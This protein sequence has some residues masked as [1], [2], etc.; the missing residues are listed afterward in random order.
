MIADE[1]ISYQKDLLISFLLL[2]FSD[3]SCAMNIINISA[4]VSVKIFGLIAASI[5]HALQ[6]MFYRLTN[7]SFVFILKASK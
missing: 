5:L 2:D 4:I 3:Y 6:K 1:E 7:F